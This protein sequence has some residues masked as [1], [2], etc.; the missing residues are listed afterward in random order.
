MPPPSVPAVL[1]LTV[2][3][4][5]V[6]VPRLSS[7]PP[8]IPDE[9]AASVTLLSDSVPRLR[10]PPPASPAALPPRPVRLAIVKLTPTPEE[11]KSKT[12]SKPPQPMNLLPYQA[13]VSDQSQ[14]NQATSQN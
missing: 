4:V 9:L 14:P 2:V 3:F 13:P 1:P 8:L 5:S 10:M 6:S 11:S 12:R 7:P